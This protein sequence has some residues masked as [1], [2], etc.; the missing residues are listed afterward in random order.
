[1]ALRGSWCVS[2]GLHYSACQLSRHASRHT[3]WAARVPD[4]HGASALT[5]TLPRSPWWWPWW[6]TWPRTADSPPELRLRPKLR[7]P[8]W[9]RPGPAGPARPRPCPGQDRRCRG[10]G[11]AVARRP[12]AAAA[13]R[14]RRCRS[15][16]RQARALN[17]AADPAGHVAAHDHNYNPCTLFYPHLHLRRLSTAAYAR[18][19]SSVQ[20]ACHCSSGCPRG[21]LLRTHVW[22]T[23]RIEHAH[24]TR[25]FAI[26][27]SS[28]QSTRVLAMHPGK[29]DS[30]SQR[31]R[32]PRQAAPAAAEQ[33]GRRQARA[34]ALRPRPGPGRPRPAA[35]GSRLRRGCRPPTGPPAPSCG[36]CRGAAPPRC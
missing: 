21:H 25:S 36:S 16:L 35:P 30:S 18:S 26:E 23:R 4:A 20:L 3:P 24:A 31:R 12:P 33:E 34:A 14:A 17:R 13:A 9:A 27:W 10:Q 28:S 6:T 8:S 7:P 11:P 15:P 29:G 22:T 32:A 2:E 5:Q 1:M 19:R